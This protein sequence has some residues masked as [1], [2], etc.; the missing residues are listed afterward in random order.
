MGA[1]GEGGGQVFRSSLALS[2]TTGKPFEIKNIR[3][4]RKKPGLMP[5]HLTALNASAAIGCAHVEGDELGSTHVIFHPH[6]VRPGNY[7]FSIGT[8]GSCTL[9]LQAILPPLLVATSP[10]KIYLEG[11]THNPMAPPYPFLEKAL[12]PLINSMGPSVSSEL[13][14]PGFFPAGGGQ[15]MV[16]IVPSERL[17]QIHLCERG[18]VLKKSVTAVVARIKDSIGHREIKT[19]KT[20][21]NLPDE[22]LHIQ[23]LDNTKGPGNAVVIEIESENCTEVFTGFGQKGVKAEK[24]AARAAREALEYLAQPVAAG[25]YLA[26]QLLIYLAMAKGGI[27]TTLSPSM[28]TTTNMEII[29]A[30]LDVEFDISQVSEYCYN[31]CVRSNEVRP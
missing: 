15:F 8:A 3:A 29:K 7:R 6:D 17:N 13:Q 4:T 12:M 16:D 9:V 2:L 28:H 26:D 14:M 19:I 1:L 5:Q 31:I 10:S 18:N 24:V 20:K 25:R 23:T 22:N 11:G 30:F 27:F 21:M